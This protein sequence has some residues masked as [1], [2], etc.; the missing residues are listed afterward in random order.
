MKVPRRLWPFLLLLA[1]IEALAPAGAF[2][3]PV[4]GA[5]R[6]DWNPASFWHGNWGA[7]GVHKGI[8][9]FARTGTPVAAAQSG[10]VLYTGNIS[11]GGTS[12]CSSPR[13]AGCTTTRTS[14]A[15]TPGKA[16]GSQP[17]H[18]SAR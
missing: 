4:A 1:L 9:I 18:R 6:R 14:T 15:S 12:R 17:A 7:S 5:A 11:L 13:A 2:V 3:Q 10:L 8:D 16:A